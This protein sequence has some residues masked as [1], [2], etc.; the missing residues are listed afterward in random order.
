[1]AQH[2]NTD[3]YAYIISFF[4]FMQPKVLAPLAKLD[5]LVIFEVKKRAANY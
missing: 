1:M 3:I 2:L 4:L 5:I